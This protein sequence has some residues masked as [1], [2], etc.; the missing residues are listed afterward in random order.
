MSTTIESGERTVKS[1]GCGNILK[2]TLANGITVNIGN[3]Y[4]VQK[5]SEEIEVEAGSEIMV[6]EI[7]LSAVQI[8]IEYH[9][10]PNGNKESHSLNG[11]S[12][13][14]LLDDNTLDQTNSNS[15]PSY[16]L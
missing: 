1:D 4:R 5:N 8:H 13:G 2:T 16:P 11:K 9:K 6:D 12:F 3:K 15:N 7:L 14:Q 10:T